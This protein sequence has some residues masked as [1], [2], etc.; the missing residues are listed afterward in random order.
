MTTLAFTPFPRC[1]VW[2]AR[3]GPC[4]SR[5]AWQWQ[6]PSPRPTLWPVPS[7]LFLS[8]LSFLFLSLGARFLSP[9]LQVPA[10]SRSVRASACVP[11]CLPA[12]LSASALPI[13]LSPCL[14][15]SLFLPHPRGVVLR[16]RTRCDV[17]VHLHWPVAQ[18]ETACIGLLRYDKPAATLTTFIFPGQSSERMC[19]ALRPK[20]GHHRMQSGAVTPQRDPLAPSRPARPGQETPAS[21]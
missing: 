21:A 8:S 4:A 16:W 13:S 9:P 6:L 19:V 10:S 1:A 17:R 5:A 2:V 14:S 18:H 3:A 7:S 20:Q 11:A 12:C 15:S